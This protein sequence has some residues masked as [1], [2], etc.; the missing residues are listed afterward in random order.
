MILPIHNHPLFSKTQHLDPFLR[1]HARSLNTLGRIGMRLKPSRNRLPAAGCGKT[2]KDIEEV[3]DLPRI[4]CRARRILDAEPV[5]FALVIAAETEKEHAERALRQISELPERG[6]QDTADAQTNLCELAA[7]DLLNRMPCGHMSDFMTHDAR[8]LRFISQIGKDSA[9]QIN[10]SSWNGERVYHG[11][12]HHREVPLQIR[13]MRHRYKLA[14]HRLHV[15]L[16][17]GVVHGAVL[18]AHLRIRLLAHRNFLAFG[19]QNDLPPAGDGIPCAICDCC[20]NAN[21]Q[22]RKNQFL[23]LVGPLL[24]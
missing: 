15:S 10:V 24:F 7:G 4:P 1:K 17:R 14:S 3:T 11:R 20:R 2:G 22:Q 18:L 12:V 19:N 8:Q 6:R 5:G 23:H 21:N 13:A 16:Q 9:R